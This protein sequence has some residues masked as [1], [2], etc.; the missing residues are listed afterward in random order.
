MN[1][2]LVIR[3]IEKK[4]FA[5]WAPLG[6]GYNAFCRRSGKTA[7]APEIIEITWFRF[8]DAYASMLYVISM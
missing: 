7:L 5:E 1:D 4:D 6:D 2:Q 8:F 3:A